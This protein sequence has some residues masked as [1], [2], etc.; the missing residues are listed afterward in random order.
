MPWPPTQPSRGH[1]RWPV[2]V[3]FAI[4]LVAVAAAVAA[5]LRPTPETKSAAGPTFGEQQVAGAKTKVCA[6]YL[7]VRRANEANATRNG[8]DDPNLQLLVAVNE[9]Q[10][11]V[12]SSAYL[13]TTLGDEPATPSD[14]AAAVRKLAD[15]YQVVTLNFLAS[16]T[17]KQERDAADQ[18]WS[19]I[20]S[21]C[22]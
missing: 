4:T 17:S 12:A 19:T 15:E 3:M 20:Q 21:L 7:K 1:A 10:I 22:K 5:W 2:F 6:A 14:L 13:L 16:D 9:R 18:A 11:C 8:G